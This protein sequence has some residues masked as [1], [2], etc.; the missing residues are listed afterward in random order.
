[1]PLA[2][3]L[4]ERCIITI[5]LRVPPTIFIG[6]L[7]DYSSSPPSKLPN[8]SPSHFCGFK[9]FYK[10]TECCEGLRGRPIGE[11]DVERGTRWGGPWLCFADLCL[12]E[13]MRD[14]CPHGCFYLFLADSCDLAGFS[15]RV[16]SF[17]ETRGW[18]FP[19][20]LPDRQV[21]LAYYGIVICNAVETHVRVG[22]CSY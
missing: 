14:G 10:G 2:R 22:G 11:C 12:E 21:W 6:T 13:W 19:D 1:M 15:E 5:T 17:Y 20:V 7:L 16:V 3:N 9:N 4:Q 8:P 18:Y